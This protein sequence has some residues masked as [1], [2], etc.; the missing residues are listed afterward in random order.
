MT[1]GIAYNL[2]RR[3]TS[4]PQSLLSSAIS[5][6]KRWLPSSPLPYSVRIDL[7]ACLG[8][9]TYKRSG[10]PTPET[11]VKARNGIIAD[12][13]ILIICQK[14]RT[15]LSRGLPLLNPLRRLLLLFICGL[16]PYR[17]PSIRLIISSRPRSSIILAVFQTISDIS[18]T[19]NPPAASWNRTAT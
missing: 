1:S 11:A 19:K 12:P 6:G 2:S 4:R 10:G 14:D 3:L 15:G 18:V 17:P 7:T 16:H 13:L 8:V 5:T 9:D